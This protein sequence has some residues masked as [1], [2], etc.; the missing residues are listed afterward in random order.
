MPNPYFR[1]KQFTVFHDRCAMKVNTDSVLLGSWADVSGCRHILDV[2]SGS[3]L[4]ALMLAQ[5]TDAFIAGVEIDEN[6]Y[7]QSL[8]NVERSPWADRITVFHISFGDFL[9]ETEE[10]YDLIVSNPPYFSNSLLPPDKGRQTARHN[11]EDLSLK[12]LISGSASLLK[13]KGKMAFVFPVSSDR[14]VEELAETNGLFLSKKVRVKPTPPADPKRL[15]VEMSKFPV[16]CEN[17]EL[18]IETSRHRYSD[19]FESLTK[20]Y[21]LDK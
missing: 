2:G 19:A 13:E 4:I 5:R 12:N 6:A 10:R 11:T 17:T 20:E 9:K 3:G 8:E 18:I 15:L 14:E 1:F 21:Y 7:S 16:K